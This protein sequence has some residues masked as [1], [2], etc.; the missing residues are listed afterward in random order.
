MK[1]STWQHSIGK[2]AKPLSGYLGGV[3][4]NVKTEGFQFPRR[5]PAPIGGIPAGETIAHRVRAESASA[6][7]KKN[8]CAALNYD[9]FRAFQEY[10][11]PAPG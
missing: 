10:A 3:W 1:K 4:K 2:S 5:R 9:H 8:A 6:V 7:G 11:R